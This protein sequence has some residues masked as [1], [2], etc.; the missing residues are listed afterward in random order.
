MAAALIFG[1]EK[2]AIR[3]QQLELKQR[4]SNSLIPS[5][6]SGLVLHSMLRKKETW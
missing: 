2:F 1:T 6:R 4:I 3:S 5:P